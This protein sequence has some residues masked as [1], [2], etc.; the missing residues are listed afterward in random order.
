MREFDADGIPKTGFGTWAQW[1]R[2]E[3]KEPD[4]VVFDVADSREEL[5]GWRGLHVKGPIPYLL[6]LDEGLRRWAG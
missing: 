1:K 6:T 5:E 4:R 3:R 2:R